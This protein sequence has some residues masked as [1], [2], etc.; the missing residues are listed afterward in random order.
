MMCQCAS[1]HGKNSYKSHDPMTNCHY[2]L[3]DLPMWGFYASNPIGRMI[4]TLTTHSQN[5][6]ELQAKYNFLGIDFEANEN[7]VEKGSLCPQFHNI[8]IMRNPIHRLV[9]HIV[10]IE[11]E[12]A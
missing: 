5:C 8:I 2:L 12:H 6:H 10:Q 4:S 9:S 1:F 11:G 3:Q 7:Y